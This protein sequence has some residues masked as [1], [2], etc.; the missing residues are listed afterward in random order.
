MSRDTNTKKPGPVKRWTNARWWDIAR[1]IVSCTFRI[2]Y[3]LRTEGREHVVRDRPVLFIS[4]HQ[5]HFDPPLIGVTIKHVPVTYLA[6]ASLFDHF[7][8]GHLMRS[9]YVLPLR[10]TQGASEAIRTIIGQIQEGRCAAMFPEG[11]R[12]DDGSLRDFKNGF[13]LLV[14]KTKVPVVCAAIEGAR[15][16]WP[17][18][19]SFPLL[20]GRI[21]VRIGEPIPAEEL[22]ALSPEDAIERVRREIETMRMAIRTEMRDRTKGAWPPPGPGDHPYWEREAEPAAAE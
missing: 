18:S 2:V 3:R 19:R 1:L 15:D 9:V 11:T 21:T 5:S 10:R 6:R 13:L 7:P 17:R 8:V 16:I 14:R 12:T 22:L 4:N 20:R